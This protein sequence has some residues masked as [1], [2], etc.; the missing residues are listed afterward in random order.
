MP[1]ALGDE[2]RR[3]RLKA[4][5]TLRAFARKVGIS[6]AHQSDI[7]HGRRAPSEEVLQEMVRI[8]EAVGGTLQHLRSFDARLG[9][10]LT[11]MVQNTPEV[12]QLLRQVRE[13]GRSPSEVLKELRDMLAERSR[14]E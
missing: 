8:L 6:A 13:S 1:S 9:E 4:G 14:K 7:E 12:G 10:D 3:L 5:Y 11:R 2:I